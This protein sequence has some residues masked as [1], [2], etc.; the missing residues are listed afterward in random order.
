M[1]VPSGPVQGFLCRRLEVGTFVTLATL[2]GALGREGL[3]W[4]FALNEALRAV[5][6]ADH[7]EWRDD[8][9]ENEQ[10]RKRRGKPG[11]AGKAAA[12]PREHRPCRRG[13]HRGP[14]DRRDERLQDE[15]D[16]D[17][18][19]G[20]DDQRERVIGRGGA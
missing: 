13:E 6:I 16:A 2:I 4:I 8:D 20:Q 15:K 10:R 7:Q 19:D 1:L 3:G 17:D 11:P 14:D 18:Q 9:K 5:A 12:Q